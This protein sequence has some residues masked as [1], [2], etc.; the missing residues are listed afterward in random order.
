[1]NLRKSSWKIASFLVVSF[2]IFKPE[3]MALALLIDGIGL[4]LFLLFLEVQAIAVFGYYFQNWFKPASKPIYKFIQKFDPYI[5]IPTKSVGAQYPIIFVHAI[6]C[7][8]VFSIG[9]LFV[10]FNSVSA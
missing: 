8:I 2:L 3:F 6:P 9:I 5:F 1:M 7:F 10:K 4:E